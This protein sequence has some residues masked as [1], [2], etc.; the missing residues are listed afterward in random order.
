M[1]TEKWMKNIPDE[2]PLSM[3]SI[4][5]THDSAARFTTA[6]TPRIFCCQDMSVKISCCPERG[7]SIYGL[8]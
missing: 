6:P 5:G 4:P 8:Y 1:R 3:I 7:S 2:T